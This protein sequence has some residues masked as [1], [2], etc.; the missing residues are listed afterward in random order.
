MKNNK[1]N[2]ILEKRI[3][4][5]QDMCIANYQDAR[6]KIEKLGW[7]IQKLNGH[8]GKLTVFEKMNDSLIRNLSHRIYNLSDNVE[9]NAF[10]NRVYILSTL[11][12]FLLFILL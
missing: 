12:L 9:S 10:W 11:I 8:V 7:N 2:S 3:D 1:Q 5:L 4:V 6:E